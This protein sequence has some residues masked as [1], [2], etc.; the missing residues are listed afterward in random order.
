MAN[1]STTVEPDSEGRIAGPVRAEYVKGS[2]LVYI[3]DYA[4]MQTRAIDN[5]FGPLSSLAIHVV[6]NRQSP[7]PGRVHLT[8]NN[9]DMAVII[10]VRRLKRRRR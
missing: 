8:D 5:L 6:V 7:L 1:G 2:I 10:H 3:R 4:I 9:V